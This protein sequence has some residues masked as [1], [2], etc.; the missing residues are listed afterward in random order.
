MRLILGSSS[1]YRRELLSRWQVP[2][3]CISPDIDESAK[4]NESPSA[5]VARLSEDKAAAIVAQVEDQEAFIIA[6]DQLAQVSGA[7]LGKPHTAD[8][9]VE[10][11]MQQAGQEVQFLTSVCVRLGG[12]WK[13]ELDVTTVRF[14]DF[15]EAE[16][17]RYVELERPLNC[18]GSFKSEGLGICLFSAISNDDPT[19]LIGLPLIRT[20]ALLRQMGYDVL[21]H[22][23]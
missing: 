8:N 7:V 1:P 6:S 14:R 10:Q 2:F 5:L 9:A 11:L 15:T 19:A 3:E 12:S 13:T 23:R 16:A 17:A 20:A 18:A 21:A 4:P 22:A